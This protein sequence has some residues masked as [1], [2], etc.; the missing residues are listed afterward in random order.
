MRKMHKQFEKNPLAVFP[1]CCCVLFKSLDFPQYYFEIVPFYFIYHW[2]KFYI[3]TL[4]VLNFFPHWKLNLNFI[5]FLFV[6]G[7][8]YVMFFLSSI[9]PPSLPLCMC[10]GQ[11]ITCRSQFFPPCGSRGLNLSNEAWQQVPLRVNHHISTLLPTL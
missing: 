6:C 4:N 3:Q 5:L 7:H 2:F 1:S 11:K 10:V 8:V 9:S